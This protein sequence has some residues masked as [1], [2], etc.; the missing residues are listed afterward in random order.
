MFTLSELCNRIWFDVRHSF[1]L[2]LHL[3]GLADVKSAFYFEIPPI[4]YRWR[5]VSSIAFEF[6][7]V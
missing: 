6:G 7:P 4:F 1:S 3:T 2:K 5:E